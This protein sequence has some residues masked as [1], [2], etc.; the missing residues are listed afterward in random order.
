MNILKLEDDCARLFGFKAVIEKGMA[1]IK[2]EISAL[3]IDSKSP[4]KLLFPNRIEVPVIDGCIKDGVALEIIRQKCT[5]KNTAFYELDGSSYV[6]MK[7]VHVQDY[8]E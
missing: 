3:V 8:Q 1:T 5:E 6:Q 7:H 4:N 2:P